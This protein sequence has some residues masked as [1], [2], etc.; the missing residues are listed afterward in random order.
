M[1]PHNPQAIAFPPGIRP[2]SVEEISVLSDEIAFKTPVAKMLISAIV[3]LEYWHQGSASWRAADVQKPLSEALT[4]Q[5]RAPFPAVEMSAALGAVNEAQFEAACADFV[6][7]WNYLMAIHHG[8]MREKGFWKSEDAVVAVLRE[9]APELVGFAVT[10][11]DGQKL[12]L[13][14][15]EVSE[16]VEALRHGNGADDKVPQFCGA[17]AEQADVLLRMGDQCHAR[18]WNVAAAMVAKLKM[19]ATRAP[20]HG[21]KQF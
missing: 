5:T 10:A 14:T 20:M 3:P 15:T 4:Y 7:S 8:I 12:A 18:G 21:G 19:N 2:L 16:T 11:F 9:H 13:Q 1:N 17:E 6:E